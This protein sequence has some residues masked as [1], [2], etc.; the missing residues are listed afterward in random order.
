[1]NA[2]HL[3]K[4]GQ[5]RLQQKQ[6][7]Q[8]HQCQHCPKTFSNAGGLAQHLKVHPVFKKDKKLP[9]QHSVVQS[10]EEKKY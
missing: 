6:A 4:Q 8:R 5:Q 10:F 9:S 2:F 3:L 7:K 1:M